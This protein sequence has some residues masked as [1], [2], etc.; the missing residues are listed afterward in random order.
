MITDYYV[1]SHCY[2][3]SLK[4][5]NNL[6]KGLVY[7][8]NKDYGKAI[9]YISSAKYLYESVYKIGKSFDDNGVMKEAEEGIDRCTKILENLPRENESREVS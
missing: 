8:D 3:T 5:T 1:R 7:K 2:N 9:E 4:A 6:Q